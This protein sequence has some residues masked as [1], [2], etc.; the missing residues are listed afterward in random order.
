MRASPA[1][2]V[3]LSRYPVS[4]LDSDVGRALVTRMRAELDRDGAC[5]LPGF[6]NVNAIE[7]LAEEAR[8]LEP[9]AYAG[10]SEASPYFFDYRGDAAAQF[11]EDHPRRMKS[12]R[13]L[14]QVACDLI[15]EDS[16]LR[17]LYEWKIWR[18]FWPSR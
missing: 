15:P 4:D 14:S 8:S 11:P 9:L 16:L 7:R 1:T 18:R 10:P 3:D 6:L 12:P 17:A 2:L 5:C 13:R